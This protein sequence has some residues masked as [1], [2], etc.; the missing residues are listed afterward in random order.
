VARIHVDALFRIRIEPASEDATAGK[1]E[2]VYLTGH[3]KHGEL[4][5]SVKRRSPDRLPIHRWIV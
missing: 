4:K 3:I 2:R 5:V 1:H